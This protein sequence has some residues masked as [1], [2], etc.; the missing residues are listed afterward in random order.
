MVT[1]AFAWRTFMEVLADRAR[2]AA[3][4]E[5]F[6]FL[7]DK[8]RPESTLTYGE[9]DRQ[10]RA[11][12][13]L[14]QA[15]GMSG[16]RA[17]LLHSPGPQFIAALFGCFYGGAVAIPAYPPDPARLDRTIPRLQAI[18]RDA[19]ATVVLTTAAM[20][21]VAESIFAQVPDLQTLR[22]IASDINGDGLERPWRDLALSPDTLAVLQYTSGSTA[23]SR[24]VMLTH[25]NLLH[26]SAFIYRAFGHSRR[27]RGVIWLPPYH[28]MGLIG[29]ILQPVY[30]GFPCVLIPPLAF[31]QRPIRW[32]RAISRYRGS[33]S[34]GPNFAYDLCV[35][36]IPFDQR[37]ELDL[38]CWEIAFNGA[39]PVRCET[40]DAFVQAFE[41]YGFRRE[42]FYPCYGLAEG[43]LAVACR[44]KAHPPVTRAFST[45]E[46]K[47]HRVKEGASGEPRVAALV[48]CGRPADDHQLAIVEPETV[49]K[50]PPNR[51]GEIW[52]SGP[53]VAQGYWNHPKNTG[54]TFQAFLA[55]GEGPFLRT[56]DLGFVHEGELFVTGRLKDLIVV[57]GRNY[58]AQDIEVAA[59]ASHAALRRNCGAAFRVEK[60]GVEHLVVVYEVDTKRPVDYAAVIQAIRLGV[61]AGV[62]LQVYA[63]VLVTPRSVPKTSS[64]K[65]RRF[66]CQ[67]L[68]LEGR[69]EVVA[70][71]SLDRADEGS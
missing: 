63:V 14:L 55:S 42:A 52:V 18:V 68:F 51:V 65:V 48:G 67:S 19:G 35:R 27:S 33:T 6:V 22:W 24:G 12:G 61:A 10:A 2:S 71:W 38:S 40:I 53:S 36:R 16:Q 69:L 45:D 25:A 50:L 7:A 58:Y 32:L 44:I 5:A 26:N 9:L 64:E 41:P 46:L 39:E 17:L 57:R 34:G 20:R 49:E 70:S 37:Q 23:T 43:T 56:G 59:E 28:D 54:R 30:G 13:A 15:A 66:L 60:E 11:I 21:S 3:D 31:F 62:D 29:G 8:N 4:E 47:Q 1:A